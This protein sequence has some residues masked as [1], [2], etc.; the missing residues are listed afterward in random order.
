M[1]TRIAATLVLFAA[2]AQAQTVTLQSTASPLNAKPGTTVSVTGTGFPTGTI[3]P[4]QTE[5]ILEPGVATLGTA[6]IVNALSVVTVVGTTRRVSFQIPTDLTV[7]SSVNYRVTV[8][9]QTSTGVVFQSATASAL[10][11]DPASGLT[12]VTPAS[13]TQGQSLT[14]AIAATGTNFVQG[15]TLANFGPG[16]ATGGAAE[17]AFGPVTVTSPTTATATIVINPAAATG[18]R[19]VILRTGA[20]DASLANGFTVN[21]APAQPTVVTLSAATTPS[22][23][24]PGTAVT[25]SGANFPTTQIN[26]TAIQLKLEPAVANAGPTLTVPAT[27]INPATGAASRTIGF[28]VPAN[29]TLPAAT[30]YLVSLT[31]TT[32]TNLAFSSGNKSAITLAPLAT[33]PKL[34]SVSPNSGIRGQSLAVT[35][36]GQD[37]AFTAQSTVNLGAG[38]TIT[39]KTTTNAT[40]I[41]AQIT[42]AADALIGARTLTI[43]TGSQVL[44]LAN[45]FSVGAS[46]NQPLISSITPPQGSV[47]T[48][49][50][51]AIKG[52]NTSFVQGQT[53]ISLGAGIT[54]QNVKVTSPTDAT[55]EAVIPL[56]ATP[57]IRNVTATTAS[58]SAFLANAFTISGPTIVI[59]SP[60]N[61]SFVNTPSITVSGRTG[62]P[63]ATVSVNGVNAINTAGRFTVA[64]PL[65][66]GRN[67]ISAVART[68]TGATSTTSILM[69]LDTT[70]PKVTILSP[71]APGLDTSEALFTVTG[72]V[73]DI[74]VGTVNDQEAQVT[75]NGVTATV[76]NRSFSAAVPLTLGL[77]TLQVTARDRVGNQGTTSIT[78]NRT[79]ATQLRILS[80]NNQSGPIQ[81]LLPQPINV[82]VSTPEGAP[83]ANRTVVF[84][85]AG[86][87]GTV[88][89]STAGLKLP[90]ISMP[91]DAQGRAQAFWTLGSHA[92]A[93]NNRIEVTS[94]GIVGVA[95]ANATATPTSP[96]KILVDSGLN[97]TGATGELLAL[98]F[99]AVVVDAGNNRLANIPIT[100]TVREGGGTI[101]G[102]TTAILNS[103]SDGRV[104]VYLKL[105]LKEGIENNVVE[106]NYANNTGAAAIFT[107]T[108]KA[109]LDPAGTI[110][111][112]VVLD[113]S[114]LPLAGATMRLLRINQGTT[115]NLPVQVANPVTTN[116]QGQFTITGAP[117]GV[118]KLMADGTTIANGK[119][120]PTLEFDITTVAG[121]NNTIGMP[122]F[123]PA[124]NLAN[125]LCVS[126]TVGGVL[127]APEMPGFSLTVAA[128]SATFPGGSKTG[129]INVTPVNMDKVPMVPG[130]GQQPRFVV[131]IQPVGT[132]FNPPAAITIP[133]VDGLKPRAVTEMYSYDHDLASFVSIG[134]GIV[135]DDG[136]L[137]RSD[138]GVGVLKAGW[139]CGGDPA[140][141]NGVVADC[142]RC[143]I[144][145]AN[146]C[147]ADLSQDGKPCFVN[148]ETGCFAVCQRGNCI[149]AEKPRPIN[150]KI[151]SARANRITGS[152]YFEYTWESSTGNLADL[153]GCTVQERVDYYGATPYNPPPPF[154]AAL[155][156]PTT[157]TPVP[158]SYGEL[159]DTHSLTKL[160]ESKLVESS[161]VATQR[162]EFHCPCQEG[163][164]RG[165]IMIQRRIF[166]IDGIWVYEL[167]KEGVSVRACVLSSDL[168]LHPLFCASL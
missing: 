78:L 54:V 149:Q 132:M 163:V 2:A 48:T 43:T 14:V 127:T 21:G 53:T 92:G 56:A 28:T 153:T 101:N 42:I 46:A 72:N 128:G 44:T 22:T 67:T 25:V 143:Q 29:I 77:N 136:M 97:Q 32:T 55:A 51:F 8:R 115:T 58:E 124:L 116:T 80:G 23:A 19:T 60:A 45:A 141:P 90:S 59:E 150:M 13:A 106:A 151:R 36:T 155:D 84:K 40:A 167:K 81:A 82:Q 79:A 145:L 26:P 99:V 158:A 164:L 17:N 86:S 122:V 107:A 34:L 10:I 65:S 154:N 114:N 61:S 11:I 162:Y 3:L 117:V 118:F 94:P 152:L 12:S 74:V 1:L 88:A 138:A 50:P 159:G 160:D 76:R 89:T 64:I 52:A 73:N 120:Y 113:N 37:T 134:K 121:Q 85:V 142:P 103:D 156:N 70:P 69:T 165:P 108:G 33:A 140:P 57:G 137:V 9:G 20:T 18:P 63:S 131:T 7:A 75:V 110:V 166:Q 146:S 35:I 123:L 147:E 133:N 16:I 27:S 5:V 30:A 71:P 6:R 135:S 119:K 93:G 4:S 130:F 144:C 41:A 87:D 38:I 91:T 39:S 104:Q 68:A 96:A 100:F 95:L 66:E 139:H 49:V 168:L 111:T 83:A 102:A 31:G 62:D 15:S 98:P 109:P 161:F 126:D 157:G 148:P 112:G 125:Q 129:C 24:N 47:G 105:G